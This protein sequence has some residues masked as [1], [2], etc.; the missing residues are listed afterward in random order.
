ME[1]NDSVCISFD[2]KESDHFEWERIWEKFKIKLF[3]MHIRPKIV[4]IKL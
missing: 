4:N 2:V 1:R 3:L